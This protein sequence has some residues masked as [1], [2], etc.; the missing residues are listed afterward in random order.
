MKRST[1]IAVTTGAALGALLMMTGCGQERGDAAGGGG[2]AASA[3]PSSPSLSEAVEALRKK[4]D[5]RYPGVAELCPDTAD[6]ASPTPGASRTLDPEAAKYAENNA[7]KSQK[8]LVGADLCRANAHARRVLPAVKDARDEQTVLS[9]L[10]RLGY[11][12][13]GVQFNTFDGELG[14]S[15]GVPDSGMCVTTRLGAKPK[16]EAHGTYMEGGCVEPT[17]G[18]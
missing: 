17:G 14:F 8:R 10:E 3:T 12:R 18:H 4:H 6:A 7:Y 15:L 16:A 11:P 13:D 1:G 2:A 9:A 5:S